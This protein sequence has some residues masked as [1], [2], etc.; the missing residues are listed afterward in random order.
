MHCASCPN[1]AGKTADEPICHQTTGMLLEVFEWLTGKKVAVREV[2]C[3]AMGP[4]ACV[5]EIEK[6]PLE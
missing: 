4:A 3:R 1:C 6:T 2:E 5:W